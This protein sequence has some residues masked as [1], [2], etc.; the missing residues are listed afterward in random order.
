MWAYILGALLGGKG[1]QAMTT[2]TTQTLNLGSPFGAN[3]TNA[4]VPAGMLK[5]GTG[6][7]YASTGHIARGP[8]AGVA[9]RQ[10]ATPMVRSYAPATRTASIVRSTP[11]TF[12]QTS[13]PVSYTAPSKPYARRV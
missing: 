3:L 1:G 13:A 10:A 11:T 8:V 2:S 6:S 9:A 4:P 5:P 12:V 7:L